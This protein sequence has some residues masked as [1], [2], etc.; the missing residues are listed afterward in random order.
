MSVSRAS[1]RSVF[2][3]LVVAVLGAGRWSRVAA[4]SSPV[5]ISFPCLPMRLIL[6]CNS[7]SS[8]SLSYLTL[9]FPPPTRNI[10]GQLHFDHC[11]AIG[12][13]IRPVAFCRLFIST[14]FSFEFLGFRWS[15]HSTL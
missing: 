2:A 13:I 5:D 14:L 6:K 1:I 4:V 15:A 7:P 12:D 8:P 9:L 10:A 11:R 3:V